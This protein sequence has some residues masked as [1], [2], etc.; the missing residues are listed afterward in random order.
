MT[1]SYDILIN[2]LP[3]LFGAG[4][5]IDL[6]SALLEPTVPKQMGT[7]SIPSAHHGFGQR[8]ARDPMQA[9]QV[10][11]WEVQQGTMVPSGDTVLLT[12]VTDAFSAESDAPDRLVATFQENDRLF[13]VFPRKIV[14]VD[15]ELSVTESLAAP[16]D[17][18][19]TGDETAYTSAVK[20]R[21]KWIVGIES[22]VSSAVF[23][24][25]SQ[26]FGYKYAEYDIATG[27]WTNKVAGGDV[28]VSQVSASTNRVYRMVNYGRHKP[29]ELF[30][31]D[32]PTVDWG[33]I[34]WVGPIEVLAGGYCTALYSYGPHLFIFKRSGMV[35]A[36]DEGE[37]LSPILTSP[38]QFESDSF[39]FNTAPYLRFLA[40]PAKTRLI[41]FDPTTLSQANMS[42]GNI[43]GF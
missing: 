42:P 14:Q 35:L 8:V 25:A 43:Q 4:G 16:I 22:K 39:G 32:D 28:A 2:S 13:L 34:S 21:G 37:V 23:G 31:G 3:Y 24:D 40:V 18:P 41:R 36:L 29:P 6:G 20:W 26:R 27:V 17:V 30:I 19:T 5:G 10:E 38:Q 15:G 1:K 9:E 33:S 11:G 12:S 7:I